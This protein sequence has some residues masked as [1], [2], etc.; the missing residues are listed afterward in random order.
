MCCK[1]KEQESQSGNI[2]TLLLQWRSQSRKLLLLGVQRK[3]PAPSPNSGAGV[4]VRW[5]CSSPAQSETCSGVSSM[6]RRT[7]F[8]TYSPSSHRHSSV[9][10]LQ[11]QAQCLPTPNV[12]LKN[13][14]LRSR[15]RK[16]L[17]GVQLKAPSLPPTVHPGGQK[18]SAG[19]Y[20][21]GVISER[22]QQR[23]SVHC[24]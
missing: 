23:G 14:E 18:A 16:L 5:C 12:Q 6:A 11:I 13:K 20:L 21:Q 1:H 2:Q 19:N 15:R 4:A 10:L 8:V 3:A 17:L 22:S 9:F 24:L 7:A